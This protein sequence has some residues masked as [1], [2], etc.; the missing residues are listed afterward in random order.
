MYADMVVD[1]L[2]ST[3][4][5]DLLSGSM[6]WMITFPLLLYIAPF[7]LGWLALIR[8]VVKKADPRALLSASGCA[9]VVLIGLI[10]GLTIRI[11]TSETLGVLIFLSVG[12]SGLSFAISYA[13]HILFW[14]RR[15]GVWRLRKKI[16]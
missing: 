13:C 8:M 4:V 12:L 5:W 3:F 16:A 1:F 11:V 9:A 2:K 6:G 14:H 7:L 15:T 10:A